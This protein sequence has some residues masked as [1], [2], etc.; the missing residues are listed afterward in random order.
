MTGIGFMECISYVDDDLIFEAENWVR[1]KARKIGYTVGAGILAACLCLTIGLTVNYSKNR[2][3]PIES[4]VSAAGTLPGADEIYPTIM[5][6]GTLYEWH[7][8]VALVD[9][10]PVGS[11]YY[12]EIKH[13]NGTVPENDCDFVS[14]FGVSGRIFLDPNKDLI[15]LE[16]TTDWLEKQLVIFEPQAT[17]ERYQAEMQLKDKEVD[18]NHGGENE[19]IYG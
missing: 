12:G 18:V 10:L 6:N 11:T 17:S 8:G 14:T 4:N 7:F 2:N 19:I 9:E 1:S 13:T 3:N 16:L 15:Y 5:V